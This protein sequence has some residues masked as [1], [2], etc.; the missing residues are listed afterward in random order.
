MIL[1]DCIVFLASPYSLIPSILVT[2]SQEALLVI[3]S[4]VQLYRHQLCIRGLYVHLI[5]HI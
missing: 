4:S 2:D 5:F 1:Y 3:F